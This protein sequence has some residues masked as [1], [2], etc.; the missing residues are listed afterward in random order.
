MIIP[1]K[2]M[3]II[4]QSKFNQKRKNRNYSV[5]WIIPVQTKQLWQNL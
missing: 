1:M 3:V 4:R 2:H 5:Y